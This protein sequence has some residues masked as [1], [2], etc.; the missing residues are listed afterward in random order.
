[1]T[2]DLVPP[3]LVAHANACQLLAQCFA[4]PRDWSEEL[5]AG[6]RGGFEPLGGEVQALAV[7]LADAMDAVGGEREAVEIAY[8]KLFLGP[9]EIDAPPYE[10]NYR[11]P[12]KRIMGVVSQQVAQAFA[13]AGL[14]PAPG[15]R[16]APDHV[17]HELE[18]LYFLAFEAVESGEEVWLQRHR[19]F[20]QQHASQWLPDLAQAMIKANRHPLYDRL[21]A[22]LAA[23]VQ[24]GI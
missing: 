3:G 24:T 4:L 9:F 12:E 7:A 22:L 19:D 5:A 23:F 13:E 21:G 1:M 10:S 6:M 15:P 17:C 2:T 16:D 8:A 18:F 14:E 11:D 20:W